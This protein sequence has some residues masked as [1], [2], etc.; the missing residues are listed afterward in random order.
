M[1]VKNDLNNGLNGGPDDRVL[2]RGMRGKQMLEKNGGSEITRLKGEM[3]FGY[4]LGRA[5]R[6]DV[7]PESSE[8]VLL[9]RIE[10]QDT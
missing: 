3:D 6:K 5:C 1:V 8:A 2:V 7:I 4:R 9:R 10:E